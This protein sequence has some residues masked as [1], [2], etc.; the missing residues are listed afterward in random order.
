[1]DYIILDNNIK[2]N[3]VEYSNF[4]TIEELNSDPITG[5]STANINI[6]NTNMYFTVEVVQNNIKQS[7]QEFFDVIKDKE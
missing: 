4:V 5:S 7:V 6:S 1:M 3:G 2:L